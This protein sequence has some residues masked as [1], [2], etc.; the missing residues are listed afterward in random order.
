MDDAAGRFMDIVVDGG[1]HESG[2][3]LV[4]SLKLR[5]GGFFVAADAAESDA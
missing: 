1:I 5:P 4:L 3:D 2:G